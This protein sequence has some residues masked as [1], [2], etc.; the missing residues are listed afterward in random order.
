MTWSIYHQADFDTSQ[1]ANYGAFWEYHFNTFLPTRGWT[2]TQGQPAN[3]SLATNG[4]E[5]FQCSKTFTLPD[6]TTKTQH[7]VYHFR[8][9]FGTVTIYEWDNVDFAASSSQRAAINS[10]S[11]VWAIGSVRECTWL[12]SDESPDAWIMLS[13]NRYVAA[14]ELPTAGWLGTDMPDYAY[15]GSISDR[16]SRASGNA[17]ASSKTR[18]GWNTRPIVPLQLHRGDQYLLLQHTARPLLQVQQHNLRLDDH[19]GRGPCIRAD[20][21]HLPGCNPTPE[22]MLDTG[23]TDLGILQWRLLVKRQ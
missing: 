22:L 23:N 18:R 8:P 6:T 13:N 7:Y 14:T 5:I 10:M 15:P 2:T 9:G 19:A 11:T 20:R 3:G 21:W 12:V 1:S 4:Y 17:S 16:R